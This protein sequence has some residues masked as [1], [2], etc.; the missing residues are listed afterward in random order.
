MIVLYVL[1]AIFGMLAIG[2]VVAK[3]IHR[4]GH[5][6]FA[7]KIYRPYIPTT[8]PIE[9]GVFAIFWWFIVIV[10]LFA[11]LVDASIIAIELFG[12]FVGKVAKRF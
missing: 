12:T 10:L 1:L 9:L 4:L 5:Y 6:V 2:V 7:R 3:P 11:L 8:D